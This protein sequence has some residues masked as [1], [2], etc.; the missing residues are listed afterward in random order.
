MAIMETNVETA[1]LTL[2]LAK[3]WNRM[4]T[5]KGDRNPDSPRGAK[6]VAELHSTLSQ[7]LFYSPTWSKV[8]VK[9]ERHKEFRVDGGHSARMLVQTNGNFPDSL[10]VTMRT[11]ECDTM[12]EA[13]HLYEQFNRQMS[14]R[15]NNDLIK[16]R[17]AYIEELKELSPGIIGKCL[18]GLKFF[19]RCHR[20][21]M[22][23]GEES[24]NLLYPNRKTIAWMAPLLE[25][26]VLL[27][28]S[29][30]VG[31]ME[32]TYLI[33]KGDATQFW[34][35][36]AADEATG[37]EPAN[38]LNRFL[39]QAKAESVHKKYPAEVY[40]SKAVHAWNAFREGKEVTTLKYHKGKIPKAV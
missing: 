11:F 36:V 21:E 1:P 27:R 25:S 28:N 12:D 37:K 31:A 2:E 39:I 8:K 16:N 24:L 38:L 40:Y 18:S 17:A 5:L 19:R 10:C 29:G 9:E 3:H 14:V 33:D 4:R 13:I 7:G 23:S 15:S 20:I 30:N 6:R 34:S 32:A 35:V 26:N 22:C